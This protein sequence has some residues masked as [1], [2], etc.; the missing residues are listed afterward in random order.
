MFMSELRP[1]DQ[2]LICIARRDLDEST[3]ESIRGLLNR[4]VFDW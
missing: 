1:E 2:L 3:V 4:D